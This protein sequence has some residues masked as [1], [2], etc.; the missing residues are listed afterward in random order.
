MVIGLLRSLRTAILLGMPF[1]VTSV[2]PPAS[3]DAEPSPDVLALVAVETAHHQRL[4]GHR[5]LVHNAEAITVGLLHQERTAK[6]RL[7]VQDDEGRAVGAAHVSMP[8]QDNEHVAYWFPSWDPGSGAAEAEVYD[9]LWAASLP[10]LAEQGRTSIQS[11]VMHP[12]P[13]DPGSATWLTPLTGTGRVAQD[14]RA[15]WFAGSG[16]VL[17]QVELYSVL[18]IAEATLPPTGATAYRIRSWVGATPP[19]LLGGMARLYNRMS[20]DTPNGGIDQDEE[21]WD[22]AEVVADDERAA[23]IGTMRLTTV[24]LDPDG[25]PVAYTVIDHQPDQ[26]H[27][28]DQ[29]DTLVHGDHRGHGLGLVVKAANLALLREHL[30]RVERVHTW[31]AAENTHM[32]AINRALGFTEAGSQGGWQLRR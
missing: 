2:P 12:A 7:L 17:E 5:D 4:F 8:R 25:A 18:R 22:E 16:F 29:D 23:L 11:W 27:S 21:H 6:A 13:A 20:V 28:A 1:T 3:A 31:N 24:A 30:P 32:L 15:R 26:P 10:I 9:A 14:E 19:E